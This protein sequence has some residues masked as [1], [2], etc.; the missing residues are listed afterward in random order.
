MDDHASHE[1]EHEQHVALGWAAL[2]ALVVILW[3]VAPIGVGILLGAFLAFMAQPLFERLRLKMG[4]HTASFTTVLASCCAVAAG[5]GGLGWIFVT[6]GTVLA[7][8]LIDSFQPGGMGDEA[9]QSMSRLTERFGITHEQLDDKARSLAGEAAA[10]AAVIAE[11]ILSATSSAL[12]GLL[13]AMLS[14]HY[15]LIH[16]GTVARRAQESLPLRPEYTAALFAE[17]REVGRSTLLGAIGTGLAQGVLAGIGFWI[18]GVPEP[19]FFGALTTVAS[20]V[21]AVGTLLVIAPVSTG[22][23][24]V[25]HPGHAMIASMWGF[26]VVIGICDYIVR[27]MLVRGESKTPTL[28]TFAALFGGIEVF[29]LKG[30][31]LG[32]VLMAIALA[33]LRLYAEETRER[34]QGMLPP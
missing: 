11:R 29:G 27:P 14:M 6:R 31:I 20:F 30:L 9:L 26:T 10:S 24:L 13:F 2:A 7:N 21:P 15:I 22:L 32:P 25:G 19:A 28:V 8:R 17:F 33:V 5:L 18:A 12:L 4:T 3:L 1:V 34:R 16:W 23:F